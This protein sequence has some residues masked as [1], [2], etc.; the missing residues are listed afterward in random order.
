MPAGCLHFV[1]SDR[2]H[3]TLKSVVHLNRLYPRAKQH[4]GLLRGLKAKRVERRIGLVSP[5]RDTV[6]ELVDSE[7]SFLGEAAGIVWPESR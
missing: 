5:R 3:I 1:R 4:G 2:H 7:I 6:D